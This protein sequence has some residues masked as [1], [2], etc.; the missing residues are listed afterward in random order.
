MATL[1]AVMEPAPDAPAGGGRGG[2]R[3]AGSVLAGPGPGAAQGARFRAL[4]GAQGR[5]ENAH[6]RRE[7]PAPVRRRAARRRRR[8]IE[9]GARGTDGRAGAR[10]HRAGEAGTRI[11]RNSWLRIWWQEIV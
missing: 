4:R 9:S 1:E 6:T 2:L 5:R 11:V 10:R 7:R 3:A 8:A